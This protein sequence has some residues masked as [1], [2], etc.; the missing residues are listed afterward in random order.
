[1]S[2][3]VVKI[4]ERTEPDPAAASMYA[5]AYARYR[6]TYFALLPVFEEEAKRMV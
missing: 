1:M 5:E 2:E 6:E 4:R 3:R